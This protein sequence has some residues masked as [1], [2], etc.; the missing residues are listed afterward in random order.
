MTI[1]IATAFIG[2]AVGV[3]LPA[4]AE[5]KDAIGMARVRQRN[6]LS[7]AEELDQFIETLA[8]AGRGI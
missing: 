5:Q 4:F 7:D 6:L 3:A 2:L 8:Q 1:R